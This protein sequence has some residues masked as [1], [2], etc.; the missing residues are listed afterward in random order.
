[1]C[2]TGLSCLARIARLNNVPTKGLVPTLVVVDI[3]EDDDENEQKEGDE[4]EGSGAPCLYG[5]RLLRQIITHVKEKGLASMVIPVV[6]VTRNRPETPSSSTPCIPITQTRRD[7][8]ST[9]REVPSDA[10]VMQLP[11]NQASDLKY[12][13]QGAIDVLE[14][15]IR[16]ESLP[17]LAIHI[18]RVYKDFLKRGEHLDAPSQKHESPWPG[19]ETP[20]PF[21]YLRE[22][23]VSDLAGQICGTTLDHPLDTAV[24][25]ISNRRK[26]VVEKAISEWRF[27]AHDLNDDELMYASLRMVQHALQM[28]GLEEFQ[29]STGTFRCFASAERAAPGR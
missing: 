2:P 6:A 27:S 19:V 17:N 9:P 7:E 23:M 4:G 12:V 21:A 10:A 24:I 5:S 18:Y 26:R 22:V 13:D 11:R 16:R 8:P 14:N 20:E 28:D 3:P 1:M 29:I 25:N 15:P